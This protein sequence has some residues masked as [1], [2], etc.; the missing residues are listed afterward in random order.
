M[1]IPVDVRGRII[2]V[3]IAVVALFAGATLLWSQETRLPRSAGT[4]VIVPP[5]ALPEAIE[6][7]EGCDPGNIIVDG[8][9]ETGGIPNSFWDPE[10]STNFGTPLCDAA[11]CGTGGGASPP[12]TGAFWA[13][14]GGIPAPE[15]ATLGQ[16][17][18]IENGV[19]ATLNFWMRIGTVSSPFTDVLN[20]RVDGAIQQSFPEPAVSE[21]AYTL[22]TIN[23]NAFANGASHQ[24]LF[25]YIGPTSGTGSYVIDDVSLD[26]VCPAVAARDSAGVY[27]AA[28]QTFFLRNFNDA[29][30]ANTV[31][32]YGLAGDL[33]IRGDWDNDND[34]SLGVYR[35]S[36]GEFLLRN[37]NTPGAAD[38]TFAF[39]GISANFRPIAGD[40]NADGTDTIGIYDVSNGVFMLR[41][42]NSA[43]SADM[44]FDFGIGGAI[45]ISGDWD[46]NNTDTIGIYVAATGVFFLKNT[47]SSGAA[48]LTFTYGAGGQTPIAGDWN[49]DGT[50]SIGLYVPAS[51]AWFLRN[52]N[53]GGVA[54][55]TFGYGPN[56]A[57]G[58]VGDW[59]GQ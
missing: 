16:T 24:V 27:S 26:I 45:P 44:T 35:P 34:D 3:A 2:V 12:R 46:N 21:G 43:G 29:G 15:T 17:V 4:A 11:S 22:R 58:L 19:T 32:G 14:F 54:D 37:T 59:D 1:F 30:P 39:G 7:P 42:S 51:G 52:S 48:D 23:L 8:G 49:N 20:V 47:N 50:D 41:N 55:V 40:W 56:G 13:W 9:Y 31:A 10:T 18:F 28:S 36:T 38:I 5:Q 57:A 53:S 25:E 6:T 33:P